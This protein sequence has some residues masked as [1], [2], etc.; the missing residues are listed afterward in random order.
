MILTI[1]SLIIL[2]VGI[3]FVSLGSKNDSG[4]KTFTGFLFILI[5]C[6]TV[7]TCVLSILKGNLN[8]DDERAKLLIERQ[9]IE[10]QMDEGVNLGVDAIDFNERV[11][12][13][14]EGHESIWTNWFYGSYWMDVEPVDLPFYVQR[15]DTNNEIIL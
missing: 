12:S 8:Q 14:Q 2:G 1:I 10:C 9:A 5:G 4:P 3:L 11:I 15:Y 13:S 7:I 6:I